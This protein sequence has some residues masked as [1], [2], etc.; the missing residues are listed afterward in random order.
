MLHG[1]TI[2]ELRCTGRAN[3]W[4]NGPEQGDSKEAAAQKLQEQ[5]NV[6]IWD[7]EFKESFHQSFLLHYIGLMERKWNKYSHNIQKCNLLQKIEQGM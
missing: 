2:P 7:N 6:N 3:S 5:W 4:N 1:W